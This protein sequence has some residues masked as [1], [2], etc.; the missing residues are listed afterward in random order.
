MKGSAGI[1]EVKKCSECKGRKKDIAPYKVWGQT[2]GSAW[3][4]I[5]ADHRLRERRG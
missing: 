5:Q 3:M 4:K 2:S 1:K